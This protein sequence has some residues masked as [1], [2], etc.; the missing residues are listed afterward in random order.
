MVMSSRFRL[1]FII[2]LVIV[3]ISIAAIF[4]TYSPRFFTPRETMSKVDNAMVNRSSLI[5]LNM[6]IYV[7]GTSTLVQKLVNI[8]INQSLIR[9]VGLNQLAELPNDSVIIIDWPLIKSSLVIG[10]PMNKVTINLTSPIIHELAGV[11]AKGD[12]VG[13]YAN[14]SDEGVVEFVLAYSWA[15]T[16]NNRLLLNLGK[17]SNDYLIAYPIIPVNT[18]QPVVIIVRRVGIGGLVIGPVY[19]NQLPMVITNIMKPAAM[20]TTSNVIDTEDPC[21]V[22]Y[23]KFE[24]AGYTNPAPGIYVSGNGTLVWAVPMFSSGPYSAYGI[25]AYM[26]GNGTY[27]WDTCL[28]ANNLITET[29]TGLHYFPINVLGYE[30][31]TESTTM[32]DNGG[33]VDY[34]VGAIDYYSGYQ[35]F[36][37]GITDALVGDQTGAFSTN[38][39]NPPP[40]SSTSSYEVF[41]GLDLGEVPSVTVGIDLPLGGSETISAS[42]NPAGSTVLYDTYIQVSNITWTF[43]IGY[44]ANNEAFPNSFEDQTPA[45]VYIPNLSSPYIYAQ[46]N[47]DFENNAMTAY[48]PC[49]YDTVQIIWVDTTWDIVVVPQSSGTVSL[50]QSGLILNNVNAPPNTYI[51]GIASYTTYIICRA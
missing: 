29:N 17:P 20:V 49:L 28:V 22:E 15:V 39:W 10:G 19:L 34:Q 4:V 31:Y 50:S 24:G 14:G 5:S 44:G 48:Y 11:I 38:S 6:P 21:Y 43:S 16:T 33:R 3:S 41:L 18:H 13:I 42:Q 32:Y 37:E 40:T 47:I 35:L 51:T 23:T 25:E 45:A 9:S 8:G 1:L 26:D 12:V 46:F 30:A 36:N 2:V 27:Y 7:V